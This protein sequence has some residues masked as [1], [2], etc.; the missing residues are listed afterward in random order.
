[1]LKVVVLLSKPVLNWFS[2]QPPGVSLALSAQLLV[3]SDSQLWWKK[4][5]AELLV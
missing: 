2:W 3:Y 5:P 1:M 4:L